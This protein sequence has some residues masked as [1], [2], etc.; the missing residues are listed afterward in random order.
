VS[1]ITDIDSI[2]FDVK[3][4]CKYNFVILLNQ[5]TPHH[6]QIVTLANP[7]FLNMKILIPILL[8][9]I[10]I[11]ISIYLFRN[12]INTKNLLYFGY[13]TAP[14]FWLMTLISGAI[15][16]NYSHLKNTISELGAIG[17]NSEIFTSSLLI[18]LAIFCILF[19]IGFYRASKQLNIS[20]IPSVL[21]VSMPI[22][23]L[24]AGIFTLGN[25]F[26]SLTGPLPLFI[27]L[28]FLVSFLLWK[29][30]KDL[31][32]LPRFSLISLIISLFIF[33]RFVESLN[34]E[35]AGLIQRFFY[36]GWTVWT[37]SI[38][39]FISKKVQ[40]ATSAN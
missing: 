13:V 1:F 17:T 22:S 6:I 10:L 28:G 31:Q 11:I 19:S 16:G 27:I 4:G 12:N 18:L 8:G 35:Y 29:R 26:H 32:G 5:K 2:S 9:L 34:Y 33:L 21:S 3:P 7:K 24:W 37:I 36:M 38:T 30:N 40:A 14:L 39:Y 25:E 20:V 15:H 23:M